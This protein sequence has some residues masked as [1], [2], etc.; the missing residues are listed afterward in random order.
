MYLSSQIFRY[1]VAKDETVKTS[2]WKH[3]QALELL[4]EVTGIPGYPARS[5]ANR[6]DY[7]PDRDWHLS[8]IYPLL[9]FKGDTSSDEIVGH[10]YV[11]PL[12]HDLLATNEDER[13]RAFVLLFN[14][15]NH[16]LTH[17]WYLVGENGTRTSWGIWNPNEVNN[18]N[19]FQDD[20]GL[21]SMEILSYLLQTYAFSGDQRFLD[22]FK[23]LIESYSYDINLINIRMISP[24]ETNFSDDELIYLSYFN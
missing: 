2:A 5:L 6:T 19:N 22:G 1:V 7:P 17:D 24:C 13:K 11:Y 21:N 9:E 4:N 20:R 3:F 18:D 10:E 16:I 23:F 12:V 14:L 15:T 8:P